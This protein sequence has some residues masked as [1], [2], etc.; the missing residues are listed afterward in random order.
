M[1]SKQI[2]G[3][4]TF[5]IL[6]IAMLAFVF[7][8]MIHRAFVESYR[9]CEGLNRPFAGLWVDDVTVYALIGSQTVYE[10]YQLNFDE[11]RLMLSIL[12]MVILYEEV[13]LKVIA[14]A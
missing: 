10:P 5:L 12:N 7:R 13:D 1:R 11:T 8:P 6:A 14:A 3:R 2:I 4:A 9:E